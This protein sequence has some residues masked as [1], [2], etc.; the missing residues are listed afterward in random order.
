MHRV[1]GWD[2]IGSGWISTLGSEDGGAVSGEGCRLV[3]V[4]LGC[5][6]LIDIYLGRMLGKPGG[7]EGR[8]HR[9]LPSVLLASLLP[10]PNWVGLE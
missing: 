7:L 4:L 10:D 3:Q 1:V 5:V 9:M 6:V 2:G 8:Q